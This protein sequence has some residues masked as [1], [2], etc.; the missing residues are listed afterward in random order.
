[1]T[2]VRTALVIGGGVAGPVMALALRKAGIDAEV[3]EAYS[4]AAD[5]IGGMLT[6]APNGLEALAL[7]GADEAVRLAGQPMS[8]MIMADG[9]G[10]QIGEFPGLDG[11]PPS[12]A[13]WRFDLCRVLREC[14]VAAGVQIHS[15]KRLVDAEESAEAVTAHFADGSFATA[16]VLIGTDG[17]RSRVRTLID[18]NAPGPRQIPLLNFGAMSSISVPA[19]P[20]AMYF[21]FGKKGFLGYWNQPD[22]RTGWFSNLPDDTPMTI[23]QA[24]EQSAEVWLGRLR[25]VYA[26]DVPGRELLAH[27]EPEDLLS[28]GSMEIMPKVP[29]WHSRRMVLVGDSAHAPSSSSGQGASLAVES[30][31][32]LA[33]CLRDVPDAPSAFARYEALRRPR[34]EKVAARAAKTN[35]GKALGPIAT[36]MMSLL[37]PL[38]LKTVMKP[39]KTL[40]AEQRFRIDWD[41]TINA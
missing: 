1:M 20:D 39:E 2:H 16:D 17:I 35:S 24:R 27:T 26:D 18:P 32:Q 19:R 11:L 23:A 6:V 38:A 33:Q 31:I 21:V 34:V 4:S 25:A 36:T 29:R 28:F 22:G 13:L 37:M 41:E 3:Y 8:S 12:R 30:A 15:G 10:R 14:A 40:G 9:R 5:T 7:V